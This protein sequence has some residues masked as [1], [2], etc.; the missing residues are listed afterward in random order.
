MA[1]LTATEC[2]QLLRLATTAY[3]SEINRLIPY[4]ERDICLHCNNYF[5][6]TVI[7]IQDQGSVVFL[8]GDTNT[9]STSPDKITDDQDR[10][11]TSGFRDGMDIAV[12]GGSN[13]GIYTISSASTDTLKL[14]ST[15][16]VEDQDPSASYN[17]VGPLLIAR[18]KWP[19]T[20]KPV[21]AQMIWHL[22]KEAKTGDVKSESIDD[23]SVT[24]AGEHMYPQRV[25]QGLS[26]YRRAVLL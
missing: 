10:F 12:F 8:R 22:L 14:D 4:V 23:Y 11:T 21:A 5:S 18:V 6:D 7:F 9:T 26:P 13:E 1:L 2:Q 25:V 24:Y 20:L 15:G 3:S 19:K 17:L 16:E